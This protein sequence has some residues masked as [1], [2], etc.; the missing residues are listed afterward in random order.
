MCKYC[1]CFS[2]F[3]VDKGKT[4]QIRS[5][6]QTGFGDRQKDGQNFLYIQSRDLTLSP[7]GEITLNGLTFA[8]WLSF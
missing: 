5:G 1:R 8:Q 7:Q 3:S 4:L 6:L 2:F